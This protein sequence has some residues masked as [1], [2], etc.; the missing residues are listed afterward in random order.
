MSTVKTNYSGS[1]TTITI[2]LA[3]LAN[4]AAR[5]CTAIVNTS[6][7]F[8]DAVVQVKIK[9]G[10]SGVSSMGFVNIYAYGTADNGTTYG[11]G[12]AGIDGSATLVIPSNLFLIG[13]ITANANATTYPSN[14]MAVAQAFGGVLPEKW[15]IVVENLTGTGFDSTAGNFSAKYEGILG[16]I[17]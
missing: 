6:N 12:L 1:G 8:L 11:E 17:A 5:Q 13:S 14:P 10:A 9:T 3:S 16:T 2:T 4:A 7:L 15:G